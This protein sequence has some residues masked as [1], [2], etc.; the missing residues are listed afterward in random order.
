M[1]IG[2]HG[3]TS[4]IGV[5]QADGGP[6]GEAKYVIGKLLGLAHCALC[7][8]T[9]SPV[10]R[11]PVWDRMVARLG[12]PFTLLHLNE[13]PEDVADGVRRWGAPAVLGRCADG[14]LTVVVGP[15]EL[16]RQDGSV[17][18]FEGTLL[19]ALEQ[20]PRPCAA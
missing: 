18:R 10:R 8:I 4:L 9:H 15:E 7:D 20:A 5:Y 11:K 13:L 1:T 14:T 6:V 16:E 3:L 19:T 17:D 12:I 2:E